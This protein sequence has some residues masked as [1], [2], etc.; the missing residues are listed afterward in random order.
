MKGYF[1]L[2]LISVGIPVAFA[3]NPACYPKDTALSTPELSFEVLWNTFQNHYAFFKLKEMN[4]HRAYRQYRPLVHTQT[5][6][7]SLAGIFSKMLAP[8]QDPKIRVITAKGQIFQGSKPWKESFPASRE[9]LA[10][11]TH[12]TLNNQGFRFYHSLGPSHHH[13]PLVSYAQHSDLAYIR[14]HRFYVDSTADVKSDIKKLNHYLDSLFSQLSST[15]G[16]MIDVRETQ[17]GNRELAYAWIG[18]F[19]S[20]R[21]VGLYGRDRRPGF[22]YEELSPTA[23]EYI[24][25]ASNTSYLGRIIV[26]TNKHTADAADVFAVIMNEISG[27]L[28]MGENTSGSYSDP[29]WFRLPNGWQV[30]LSNQRYYNSRMICYEGMGTPVDIWVKNSEDSSLSDPVLMRALQE[31]RLKVTSHK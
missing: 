10:R 11:Q 15:T 5:T 24:N 6:E 16:L 13:Q 9:T 8:L 26:L 28:V 19:I 12:Q 25:P 7:D 21:T 17:G 4:W 18:R 22:D 3:Q 20:K 30:S 29:Y 1:F 31:L 14:I 23:A 2:L 27:V